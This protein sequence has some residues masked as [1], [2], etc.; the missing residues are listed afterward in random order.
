MGKGLEVVDA[1]SKPL[2]DAESKPLTDA[3]SK[4]RLAGE[5]QKGDADLER[6][7]TGGVEEERPRPEGGSLIAEV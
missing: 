7:V 1:K 5:G 6:L 4:P 3:K 2:V